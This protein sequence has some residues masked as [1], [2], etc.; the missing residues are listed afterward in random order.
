VLGKIVAGVIIIGML[1]ILVYAC[2]SGLP[3][4]VLDRVGVNVR[5]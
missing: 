2:A 1:F 4:D 5:D 3:G